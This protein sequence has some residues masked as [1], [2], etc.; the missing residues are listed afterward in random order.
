MSQPY[1]VQYRLGGNLIDNPTERQDTSVQVQ[2]DEGT[3]GSIETSQLTFVNEAYTIIKE[4]VESGLITE[5]LPLTITIQEGEE[6][7]EVF[8]GYLDF[9]TLEDLTGSEPKFLASIV[10]QDGLTNLSESLEGVTFALLEAKGFITSS[11]YQEVKYL[12]EKQVALLEQAFLA[13]SVFLMIKEIA[14]ASFRLSQQIAIISAIVTTPISGQV[15]A[16]IY[17][18]ASA[19]FEIAY[20]FIMGAALLD[21]IQQF[22]ENLISFER[23]FQGIKYKTALEKIFSYLGYTFVSPIP[24]IDTYVYLPSKAEGRSDKGIPF[25]SDFGFVANE[26]VSMV[27]D[28]FRAEIFVV[29]NEVQLRTKKDPFFQSQS[30]FQLPDVLEQPFSLNINEIKESRFISFQDDISDAYT[31]SNWKGTSFVVT[32]LPITQNIPKNNLIKGLEE[33]RFPVALGNRKE[34]LSILEEALNTFFEAANFALSAL[35]ASNITN[36][37][38]ARKGMLII[39]Q[40]FFNVPKVLNMQGNRLAQN[41]REGLSARYLWENYLN[42]DSFIEDNFKR[43][44]KVFEGIEIPFSYS[45]YKK[46]KE[47]SYFIT[48]NGKRGKFTSLEWI[49]EADRAE[50]SFW[51]EDVYTRNLQE[52]TTEVS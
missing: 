49:I 7:T 20:I 43:Q 9:S 39:S 16:L 31:V 48:P 17:A 50:A 3:Q 51:V 21:L 28:M 14:E 25:D 35:G 32:T 8:N 24:E 34:E 41:S 15:G 38:Q 6:S 29:N 47:N 33:T 26:F 13:L 1:F 44:R 22:I 2:F 45:D 4:T 37:I 36:T 27:L 12:I 46:V 10:E 19:L 18:V 23:E 52:E 40:P 11:D 30:T 42:Y 5:G